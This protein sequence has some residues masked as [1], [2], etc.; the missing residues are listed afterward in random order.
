MRKK[1]SHLLLPDPRCAS[2]PSSHARAA[3]A[4]YGFTQ[5][6]AGRNSMIW[7]GS[8][9]DGGSSAPFF[10]R[11][12]DAR[13]GLVVR[14][15]PCNTEGVGSELPARARKQNECLAVLAFISI[16]NSHDIQTVVFQDLK[17]QFP[18]PRFNVY[19]QT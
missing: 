10:L 1:G 9:L 14:S 6:R 13:R 19:I 17:F 8:S 15:M 16:S 5:L 2:A 4:S 7:G 3:V 18:I 12:A 11:E